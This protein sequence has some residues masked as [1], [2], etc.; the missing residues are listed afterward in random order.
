MSLDPRELHLARRI[1]DQEGPVEKTQRQ[2]REFLRD[3]LSQV[4]I[5]SIYEPGCGNHLILNEFF[6]LH[7]ITRLDNKE[8]RPDII[9]GDFRNTPQF[10]DGIFDAAF[11][12]DI[13]PDRIAISEIVRTIRPSG[14]LIYSAE[15]CHT[16]PPSTVLPDQAGYH[17]LLEGKKLTKGNHPF[18]TYVKTK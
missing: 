2:T 3:L 13:H 4:A 11:L 14:L 12:K 5:S 6:K 17:P 9:L 15:V 1:K 7:Q 8:R 10:P 16:E 18:F